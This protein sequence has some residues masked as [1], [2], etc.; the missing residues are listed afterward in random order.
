MKRRLE[1]LESRLSPHPRVVVVTYRPE[2]AEGEDAPT[3]PTPEERLLYHH[4]LAEALESNPYAQGYTLFLDHENPRW[5]V[6][7]S[8][9]S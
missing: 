2:P 7:G 6:W 4:L 5:E 1:H 8:E 9:E 3:T